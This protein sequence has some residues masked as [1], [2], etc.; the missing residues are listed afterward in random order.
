MQGGLSRS[1]RP[2][3]RPLLPAV[4]GMRRQTTEPPPKKQRI[5]TACEACRARKTKVLYTL[6]LALSP[7]LDPAVQREPPEV[8]LV[9]YTRNRLCLW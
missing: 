8:Y 6:W 5:A 7:Y 4:A 9:Y 2:P 3:P 1:R